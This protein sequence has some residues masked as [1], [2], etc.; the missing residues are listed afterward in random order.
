MNYQARLSQGFGKPI[1][2]YPLQQGR[3]VVVGRTLMVGP[4]ATFT[5]FLLQYFAERI[6]RQWIADEMQKGKQGHPIGQWTS[7]M[8]NQDRPSG[9]AVSKM[10]INNGHRSL[11][12]ASYNLYLIEHHYEQ[13][14]E[15]LFDRMLNRVRTAN[16][17]P[18]ALSEMNAAAS[19]LK[20]GFFLEYENDLRPGYHAEFTATYPA[21]RRKF[22]V[23]VK[24]R[25]GEI[26]KGESIVNRLKLKNKLSQALKKQL[27]WTRVVF[28]D[29]NISSI[30]TAP[31]ESLVAAI[32][33][34]VDNAENTLTIRGNPAP[35][36]YLFLINQPF[37]YNL[38]SFEGAPMIGAIGFR[39]P[40][41]KKSGP[42]TF[43][44]I[45]IGREQHP[46]MHALIS[47]MEIHVEPPATFDGEH[48]EFAFGA[49]EGYQR[50]IV[51]NTY[52]VPRPDGI[53]VEAI[54]Q[55]ASALP[56]TKTI[57][58]VFLADG[59]SFVVEAPMSEEEI[60]AYARSPKTFFGILQDVG[61]RVQDVA[62]L[63]DFFYDTYRNTPKE[64]LLGF[65]KDH[66]E[67]ERLQTLSQKDLAIFVCEQ[68]ALAADFQS[69]VSSG[70]E[71]T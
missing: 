48:P 60:V 13:Y 16:D 10:R 19:F 59:A 65:L 46:E 5:D 42:T 55:S 47:S 32:S 4:W 25:T 22:S 12:S 64:T 37:H 8:R 27:P 39:L 9:T 54:L 70:T 45:V 1:Q 23:E 49:S 31:D 63:A 36:A 35:S 34:Q 52:K 57:I 68:W 61:R 56:E 71:Q 66:S 30:L 17:F 69:K 67:I 7:A 38:E 53:E 26:G 43:R 50:W 21:T 44:E 18:S 24:T 14:N 29:L 6:G 3:A 62:Q 33:A 2:S 20:A 15:P 11:L 58:G 40:T 28:I 51:G 41:F